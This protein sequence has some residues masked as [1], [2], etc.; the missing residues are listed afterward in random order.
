MKRK[1]E[2]TDPWGMPC[3]WVVGILFRCRS[4]FWLGGCEGRMKSSGAA[5]LHSFQGVW[6]PTDWDTDPPFSDWRA[7][8]PYRRMPQSMAVAGVVVVAFQCLEKLS[9]Q[10][11]GKGSWHFLFSFSSPGHPPRSPRV[12]QQPAPRDCQWH[13]FAAPLDL[14]GFA[15]LQQRQGRSHPTS[16][17]FKLQA[18]GGHTRH[19]VREILF[20]F[21][22]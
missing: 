2:S 3:L 19:Q 1:G 16:K 15:S 9:A 6:Q 8:R 7:C 20:F 18:E 11:I 22:T 13:Y 17:H 21:I 10:L 14:R 4:G 5:M 12:H